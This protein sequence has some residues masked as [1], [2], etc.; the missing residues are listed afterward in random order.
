MHGKAFR[1]EHKSIHGDFR[2]RLPEGAVATTERWGFTMWHLLAAKCLNQTQTED[3][4]AAASTESSDILLDDI[5]EHMA[6]FSDYWREGWMTNA[7][8]RNRRLSWRILKEQT[9]WKTPLEICKVVRR[10]L[11]TWPEYDP[12]IELHPVIRAAQIQ[13]LKQL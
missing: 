5:R 4:L 7:D 3:F 12:N 10:P 6:V 1:E 13:S 9:S 8:Y 2:G 11:V